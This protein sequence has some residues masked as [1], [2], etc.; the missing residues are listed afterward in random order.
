MAEPAATLAPP[1]YEKWP[2]RPIPP[3]VQAQL[4]RAKKFC[5]DVRAGRVERG[6]DALALLLEHAHPYE[7]GD[8]AGPD[9]CHKNT[10]G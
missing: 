3:E 4:D 6:V 7:P 10:T 8:L 2:K 5:E 9:H 1:E